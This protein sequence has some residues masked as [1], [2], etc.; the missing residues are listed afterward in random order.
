ML[1]DRSVEQLCEIVFFKN[2]GNVNTLSL[3]HNEIGDRGV[4]ALARCL[5][6]MKRLRVLQLA[7]NQ[8]SESSFDTLAK[9]MSEHDMGMQLCLDVE[10]LCQDF[11]ILR[12]THWQRHLKFTFVLGDIRKRHHASPLARS[13]FHHGLFDRNAIRIV[14][15]F[16]G[17]MIEQ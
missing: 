13:F 14:F 7:G 2:I 1:S 9:A 4:R 6:C 12:K 5:A 17:L 8:L 10:H 11:E 3:R 15:D 16:A